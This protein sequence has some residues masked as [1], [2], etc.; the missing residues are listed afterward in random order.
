MSTSGTAVATT[1][2]V[3]TAGIRKSFGGVEVLKGVD[4]EARSG[5]V[6]ALLGEN[7]AGKSTLVKI[8]VG[9]YR[10]NAGT[11]I[12]DDE[13][14]PTLT[15]IESRAAGISMIAQEFNDAPTLTV[16]ENISLGR[17]P[18]RRGIVSWREMNRRARAILESLEADIDVEAEI[19]TLTV[20]ERQFVEIA[21]ALSSDARVLILDEPTAALSQHEADVLFDR[22]RRLRDQGQAIVYITHRLDEVFA[23]SDR[24]QVLRDGE[25]ALLEA[26]ESVDRPQLVAA[27]VGRHDL[28]TGR[29]DST[30]GPDG[31]VAL[32]WTGASSP[33]NFADVNLHVGAGEVVALFGKLGSGALEIG[34]SAFGLEPITEGTL[35]IG[36]QVADLA[37]PVDAV[38]HG[39]GFLSEDRKVGG[40]FASRPV[41]EN[42]AVASWPRL[43][44]RGILNADVEQQAFN[45]WLGRLA[46][47]SSGQAS[48]P[49]EELSGGNQQKVLVSRWLE[50]EANALV[51]LEPTRGVDV[52]ARADLYRVLR[53][54]AAQ[55]A[56]ILIVTS[57]YEEVIA[58]ADRA[59]VVAKGRIT[60]ALEGDD[61][62]MNSLL[63][64]AGG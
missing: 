19:S 17:I 60:A 2:V 9:D 27:M 37:G 63:T 31:D 50:R 14:H 49:M 13:A 52:G 39:I 25:V 56:A 57:D 35:E 8:I 59:S 16:A 12:I 53:D 43:A 33:P 64:H 61:I 1:T 24:V 3:A 58:V 51:M 46:I 5:S 40:A 23:L 15:P 30:G 18:H 42:V 21:R 36:G 22:I 55:G 38:N 10:P 44:T 20:G 45:R 29:P 48:Q 7:G 54:L 28:G 47:R 4:L 6:L 26:T 34:R 41:G 32:R 11:V 62:N